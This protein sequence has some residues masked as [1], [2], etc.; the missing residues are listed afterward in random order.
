MLHVDSLEKVINNY[1]I[2]KKKG[3]GEIYAWF[4]GYAQGNDKKH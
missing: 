4:W 3:Y 1:K 2:I